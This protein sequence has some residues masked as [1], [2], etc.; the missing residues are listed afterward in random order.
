MIPK[1][2]YN[3]NKR[4]IIEAAKQNGWEHCIHRGKDV[5][6]KDNLGISIVLQELTDDDHYEHTTAASYARVLGLEIK[7]GTVPL[8][9]GPNQWSPSEDEQT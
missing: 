6:K 2:S 7:G 3:P 5:L 4:E 8:P 1:L 9:T